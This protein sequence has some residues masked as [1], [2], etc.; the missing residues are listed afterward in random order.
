MSAA[1]TF[2]VARDI[3]S[4]LEPLRLLA[5]EDPCLV[6]EPGLPVFTVGSA[7]APH[8]EHEEAEQRAVLHLTVD[9]VAL[10]GMNRDRREL[11]HRALRAGGQ[12]RRRPRAS[13]GAARK[14][15]VAGTLVA[16]RSPRSWKVTR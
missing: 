1:I 6:G 11:E 13:A 10:H 7:V 8:V 15:P 14:L 16:L 5:P 9:A 12:E 4:A 2:H 3:R